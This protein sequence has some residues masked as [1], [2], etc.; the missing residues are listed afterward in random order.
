MGIEAIVFSIFFG[1][2]GL[3]AFVG[4]IVCAVKGEYGS[5]QVIGIGCCL[6]YGC[7]YVLGIVPAIF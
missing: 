6:I 3:I 1:I 2:I 7:L 5:G 4:G